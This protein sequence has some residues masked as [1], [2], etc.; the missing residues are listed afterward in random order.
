MIYN[1]PS[2]YIF[3]DRENKFNLFLDNCNLLIVF[4]VS[5]GYI[6]DSATNPDIA[7]VK[8]YSI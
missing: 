4:I 3:F 1:I 5:I 7:P 8:K 2:K 6:I